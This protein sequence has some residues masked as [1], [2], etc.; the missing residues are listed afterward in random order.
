MKKVI[1]IIL[2]SISII[3]LA[4]SQKKN[5][6][7]E[8]ICDIDNYSIYANCSSDKTIDSLYY[9]RYNGDQIKLNRDIIFWEGNDKLNEF[10][11]GLYYNRYNYNHQEMN[12]RVCYCIIFDE[13]LHIQDIRFTKRFHDLNDIV[14]NYLMVYSIL[15][16]T[17]GHWYVENRGVKSWHIYIGCHK[18]D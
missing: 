9:L 6:I 4:Y 3:S 10:I 17:E 5:K 2:I 8:I 15:S 13:Y 12:D 14:K 11:N 1:L 18:F 16:K 7:Q